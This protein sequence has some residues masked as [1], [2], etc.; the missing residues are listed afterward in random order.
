[1]PTVIFA[2]AKDASCSHMAAALFNSLV[3]TRRWRGLAVV[4]A[5]DAKA[6]TR[7]VQAML[8][9]GIDLT[10]GMQV[11]VEADEVRRVSMIVTMG[12]TRT[13]TPIAHQCREEW[14][15]AMPR[16]TGVASVRQV[17]DE[18][19]RRVFALI[20]REGWARTARG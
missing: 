5:A 20:E 1:M 6:R 3:G 12:G 17:R 11:A 10:R 15:V 18:L 2:C 19:R 7:V 9:L 16:R 4:A 14:V 13:C 8:E